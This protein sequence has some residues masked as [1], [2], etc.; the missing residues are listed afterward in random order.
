[1][2]MVNQIIRNKL[3]VKPIKNGFTLIEVMVTIT[4]LSVLLVIGIPTYQRFTN[5]QKIK[6]AT[7]DLMADLM[8]ARS[9]AIKRNTSINI[10]SLTGKCWNEGWQI[11]N[12]SVTI[13]SHDS[14]D[15]VSIID[16]V[17]T[18]SNCSNIPIITY[19]SAGR[20]S[21]SVITFTIDAYPSTSSTTVR[22]ISIDFSGRAR[23]Y[24]QTGSSC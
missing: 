14:L 4:V 1:M 11:K 3:L 19:N 20:L 23:S 8:L 21:S 16:S 9:E 13:I 22:C 15:G 2:I 5:T 24:L 10:S 17:N 6:Y 7:F 12:G 18:S